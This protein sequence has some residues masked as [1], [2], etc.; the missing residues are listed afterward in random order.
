MI[1]H[2]CNANSTIS[3]SNLI[4]AIGKF[5]GLHIGH[6]LVIKEC[7]TLSKKYDL[8]P[9]VLTFHPYPHEI[10]YK[11]CQEKKNIYNSA[12]KINLI[13][14]LGILH[15]FVFEFNHQ[16]MNMS[17][18]AFVH[19]I[20]IKMFKV[21]AVVTGYNFF[22]GKNQL[23]D[24]S[25]LTKASKE[26]KFKYKVI[27][28]LKQDH[29]EVSSSKVRDLLSKGMLETANRILGREYHIM[30]KII[31]GKKLAR[32]LGFKTANIKLDQEYIYPLSGVYLVRIIIE[33]Q[34][35]IKYFG[36]ANIGIKPT[37]FNDTIVDLEVHVFKFEKNIYNKNIRVDFIS[38]LRP[39]RNLKDLGKL[40]FQVIKDISDA[41]YIISRKMLVL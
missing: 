12:Q 5:D 3:I 22:F 27:S 7:V 37:I 9:A 39:E 25:F 40:K 1:T 36:V 35:D 34:T 2:N 41:Q 30:S 15:L 26:L 32:I 33:N 19:D 14:D 18:I 11:R 24:T 21:K 20:L 23:G 31:Y 8:I 4:L 29:I 16:L 28:Q 17:H 38:F 6:Q 13:K 10:I